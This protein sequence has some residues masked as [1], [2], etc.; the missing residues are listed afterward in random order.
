M[1]RGC[2]NSD[3]RLQVRPSSRVVREMR[4]VGT[5]VV[6]MLG[7]VPTANAD[8]AEELFAGEGLYRPP[9]EW[10][11]WIRGAYGIA[12]DH[13]AA[14]PRSISPSPAAV[15]SAR[16]GEL[17]FGVEASV[18]VSPRGNVRIGGWLEQRGMSIDATYGGVEV[19]ITRVPRRL[20]MFFYEGHGMLAIRAGGSS[21]RRT[22]SIAYGYLA[23]FWLEGPCLK[24]FYD[25]YTGVCSPRPERLARYMAGL[26]VV[27]TV[28]RDAQDSHDWSATVGLEFEPVAAIRMF[29]IARDWY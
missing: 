5:L 23:P 14:V 15:T 7:V 6:T 4:F 20:D 22:A 11:T 13:A 25:I 29:T 1:Q 12:R 18:P 3:D 19:V 16:G 21:E 28:T 2:S 9:I 17:A 10:S 8:D 24:R 27:A 26:R